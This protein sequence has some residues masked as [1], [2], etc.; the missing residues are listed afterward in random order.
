MIHTESSSLVVSLFSVLLTQTR[1]FTPYLASVTDHPSVH[2]VC[3]LRMGVVGRMGET[4]L[5]LPGL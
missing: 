3:R 1:V 4:T 2:P 5:V